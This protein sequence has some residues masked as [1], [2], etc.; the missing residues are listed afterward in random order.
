MPVR[1]DVSPLLQ[2]VQCDRRSLP[3]KPARSSTKDKDKRTPSPVVVAFVVEE[4]AR[5]LLLLLVGDGAEPPALVLLWVITGVVPAGFLVALSRSWTGA[6]H[7]LRWLAP[8]ANALAT[9]YVLSS[10]GE[11]RAM[12]PVLYFFFDLILLGVL[13]AVVLFALDQVVRKRRSG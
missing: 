6:A 10:E 7:A 1:Q 4:L 3:M 5:L 11:E 13:A 8:F 12:A 9:A 2:V